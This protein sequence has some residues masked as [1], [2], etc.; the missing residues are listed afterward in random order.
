MYAQ[1]VR[2]RNDG[3]FAVALSRWE[4]ILPPG[5]RGDEKAPG[6]GSHQKKRLNYQ[7]NEGRE[8]G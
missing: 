3:A 5:E 1:M 6:V 7:K 2:I 4:I 8:R